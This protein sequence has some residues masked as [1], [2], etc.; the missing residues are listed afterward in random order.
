LKAADAA[1]EVLGA[2]R[3]NEPIPKTPELDEMERRIQDFEEH[4]V[5]QEK[6]AEERYKNRTGGGT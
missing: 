3:R 1:F 5:R 4:Q 6:E 2:V